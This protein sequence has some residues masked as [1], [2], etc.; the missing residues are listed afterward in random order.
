MRSNAPVGPGAVLFCAYVEWS[1][2]TC[3]RH[4]ER[5]KK[6]QK[7]I[8]TT[9]WRSSNAQYLRRSGSTYIRG[10]NFHGCYILILYA[11]WHPPVASHSKTRIEMVTEKHQPRRMIHQHTTTYRGMSWSYH[12]SQLQITMGGFYS[13]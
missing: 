10:R 13:Q 7:L 4:F 11:F 12:G 2:V 8:S 3:W 6:K 1:Q 9:S 5:P